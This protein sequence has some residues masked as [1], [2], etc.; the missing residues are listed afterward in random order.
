MK[1]EIKYLSKFQMKN[2]H[3]HTYAFTSCIHIHEYLTI[4]R[5]KTT[6][7]P[8]RKIILE[9]Y[10]KVMLRVNQEIFV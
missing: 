9:E 3:L 10:P 2:D 8:L 6:K 1:N 4:Y 7:I 5:N